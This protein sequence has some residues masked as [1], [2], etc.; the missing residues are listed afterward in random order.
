MKMDCPLRGSYCDPPLCPRSVHVEG[1]GWYCCDAVGAT[2]IGS[3]LAA[4]ESAAGITP[5]VPRIVPTV[6]TVP[7]R[8]AG[9]SGRRE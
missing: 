1:Q 7:R 5:N 4:V 2:L 3:L 9:S 6:A 8:P